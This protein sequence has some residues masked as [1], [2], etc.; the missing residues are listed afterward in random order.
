MRHPRLYDSNRILNLKGFLSNPDYYLNNSKVSGMESFFLS[1]VLELREIYNKLKLNEDY[2]RFGDKFPVDYAHLWDDQFSESG[3]SL[4]GH[5]EKI[6]IT[7]QN[8]L[9]VLASCEPNMKTHYR[10]SFYSSALL[11]IGW[12]SREASINYDE[13]KKTIRSEIASK[14]GDAR[15][16]NDPKEEAM[17]KIEGEHDALKPHQKTWGYLAQF[18]RAMQEKYPIIESTT[19]IER[20]IRKHRK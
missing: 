6:A 19:S 7:Y 2:G 11:N 16:A 9:G 17:L 15:V 13:M 20:R 10:E 14:A 5:A 3:E 1:Q 18:A 12:L 4:R 8:I